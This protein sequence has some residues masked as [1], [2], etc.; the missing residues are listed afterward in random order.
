MSR[1]VRFCTFELQSIVNDTCLNV[2]HQQGHMKTH[3]GAL[4]NTPSKAQTN[5]NDAVV[6][7]S[8]HL[9][10]KNPGSQEE[11]QGLAKS[12]RKGDSTDP[13][14]VDVGSDVAGEP[15]DTTV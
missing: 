11:R 1:L 7:R 6:D 2:S 13:L 4:T 14:P 9:A 12:P 5:D 15:M 3:P 10:S 8:S